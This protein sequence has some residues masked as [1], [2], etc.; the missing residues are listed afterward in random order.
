MTDE[1]YQAYIEMLCRS[2][3]LVDEWQELKEM[4]QESQRYC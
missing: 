1:E 3:A 4:G 2:R